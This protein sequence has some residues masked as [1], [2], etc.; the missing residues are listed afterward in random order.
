MGPF[1]VGMD[2][3]TARTLRDFRFED[4]RTGEEGAIPIVTVYRGDERF[5]TLWP[6]D[7]KLSKVIARSPSL[8]TAEGVAPGMRASEVFAKL[9]GS[10]DVLVAC[11]DSEGTSIKIGSYPYELIFGE[12]GLDSV[13]KADSVLQGIGVP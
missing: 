5:A 8:A 4:G 11:E 12:C 6:S 9:E 1:R 10:P 2:M 13:R 3:K 7:G